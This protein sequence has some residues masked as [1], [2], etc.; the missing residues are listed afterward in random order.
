MRLLRVN[1]AR[2]KY[3]V[4]PKTG[5]QHCLLDGRPKDIMID[6]RLKNRII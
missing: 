3:A 6:D 2:G 5:A 4:Y 1:T